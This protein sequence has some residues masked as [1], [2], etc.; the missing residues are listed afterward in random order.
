MSGAENAAGANSQLAGRPSFLPSSV[1]QTRQ[2]AR[3]SERAGNVAVA[4]VSTAANPLRKKE[5]RKAGR[6]LERESRRFAT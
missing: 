4:R 6:I 5:R 3:A 1:Q 2:R